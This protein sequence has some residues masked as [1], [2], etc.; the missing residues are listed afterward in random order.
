M[1]GLAPRF[2]A[3][4]PAQE[5]VALP[6]IPV[7][8]RPTACAARITRRFA[9]TLP[10]PTRADSGPTGAVTKEIAAFLRGTM[11][12]MSTTAAPKG[13]SFAHSSAARPGG[14]AQMKKFAAHKTREAV[15]RYLVEERAVTRVRY[16][17]QLGCAATARMSADSNVALVEVA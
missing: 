7:P 8:A 4:R 16:A 11:G 12:H 15:R 1:R 17:C 9:L 6:G 14:V 2:H 10:P 3:A 5:S 13:K